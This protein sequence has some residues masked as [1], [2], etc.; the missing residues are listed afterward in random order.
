MIVIC[1]RGGRIISFYFV[2]GIASHDSIG[3]YVGLSDLNTSKCL[4]KGYAI[5]WDSMD[6]GYLT[7][8]IPLYH[9][10]VGTML[11]ER[12]FATFTSYKSLLL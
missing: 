8:R 11:K 9:D 3:F 12:Y 4:S 7:Q 1:F 5:Q 10:K 6:V 2:T